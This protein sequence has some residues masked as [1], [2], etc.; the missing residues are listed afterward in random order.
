MLQ[1]S[2]DRRQP[3]V[4]AMGLS[5]LRSAAQPQTGL[6]ACFLRCHT[7]PDIVL[8][9]HRQVRFHFLI[10]VPIERRRLEKSPHPCR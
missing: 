5:Q 8:G 2:F 6:A 1:Q 10:E 7:P 9:E 4:L 3:A